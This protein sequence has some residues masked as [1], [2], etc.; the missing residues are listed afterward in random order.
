MPSDRS[1]YFT[2]RL[3]PGADTLSSFAAPP[4]VPVI[5][6]ARMTS[7][8]RNVIMCGNSEPGLERYSQVRSAQMAFRGLSPGRG[9]HTPRRVERALGPCPGIHGL[10]KLGG[11]DLDADHDIRRHGAR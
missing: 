6:T 5:I 4:I 3:M 1:A 7:T 2:S 8:W 10:R 9:D 11:G